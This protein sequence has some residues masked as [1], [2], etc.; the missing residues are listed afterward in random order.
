[1]SE[2]QFEKT[3]SVGHIL[4]TASL[5]V[6]AF[7]Y[8]T[9]LEQRISLLEQRLETETEL[10]KENDSTLRAA[11]TILRGEVKAEIRDLALK[12][13]RLYEIR[14]SSRETVMPKLT[15][16]L[17]LMAKADY[18]IGGLGV[19]DIARKYCVAKST[20]SARA[21][22]ENWQANKTEQAEQLKANAIIDLVNV[23][24]TTERTLSAVER[25]CFD[26]VV[27]D[28][29]A[30]RLQSDKNMQAV[31]Q[32]VMQ[33]LDDIERPSEAKAIMDVLKTHREARLGKMPDTQVNIQNNGVESLTRIERIVV[34]GT[35][36]QD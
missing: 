20:V 14:K 3:L 5:I 17:W 1:M 24:R 30:F 16:E 11:D 26:Q 13:D 19:S 33:M 2:W 18:E 15:D 4:T 6:T 32:K 31:E 9:K 7:V 36:T 25:Q 29:V 8:V 23:E 27:A 34:D 10:R 21:K 28:N 22:K 35:H 12:I